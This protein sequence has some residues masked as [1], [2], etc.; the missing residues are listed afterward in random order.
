MLTLV[1][2]YSGVG[3]S[4]LVKQFQKNVLE[5]R[6]IFMAGKF[7]QYK[8]NIPY[9]AFIG[10]FDER[11]KSILSESDEMIAEWKTNFLTALG[12]NASLVTE[13]VPD[14]EMITG[15]LPPTPKL[16]PAEQEFRF[17]MVLL[18]FVYCFTTQDAPLV[19]FLD[20][21]QWADLPSLNL[22]ER[23]LTTPRKNELLIIGAYR[24]NEVTDIHPLT[25]TKE[26]IIK[27]RVSFE[28]IL[29]KPLD[30]ETTI[31]IVAESFGMDMTQAQD[32]GTH[33]FSKTRGN[34]FFINRFLQSLYENKYVYSNDKG[35]WVWDKVTLESLEFT[36]NVIDLMARELAMLPES[37]QDI[38]KSASLLGSTFNLTNLS[39]ITGKTQPEIFDILSPA[40]K[41]GYILPIDMNYRSLSLYQTGINQTVM[42]DSK[43]VDS[44]FRFLHDRVQQSAYAMI[45]VDERARE[46]LET[47][48]KL[49]KN[50]PNEKLADEVFDIVTHYADSLHLVTDK[51]EKKSLAKLFLLAGKKAKDSTSYDVAVRYLTLGHELLQTDSWDSDYQLTFDLFSE[52]VEC[53]NLNSNH[54]KSEILFEE[55]LK[56]ARTRFEKLRVY[57]IQNSLYLKIGNTAKALQTGRDAHETLRHLFS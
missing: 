41:S 16:Q 36:D 37:T 12:S 32:L 14:L 20:D 40:L 29:L 33:V 53:E 54:E 1:S 31:K 8:K 39:L 22:L 10:A 26:Q 24:S 55:I 5:G 38:M 19:I 52:L 45:P 6:G 21:L 18:D 25:F 56:N 28:E 47:G 27:E 7:D 9:F 46:H 57:Y 17:R 4:V 49:F 23:I 3:K 43:K 42:E 34:P 2:G 11:I 30:Q 48:R 51:D 13:V 35:R 44:S 50:T 15:K